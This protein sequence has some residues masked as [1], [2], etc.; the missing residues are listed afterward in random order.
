MFACL[1]IVGMYDEFGNETGFSLS[2]MMAMVSCTASCLFQT[3]LA[4]TYSWL[5]YFCCAI[6]VNHSCKPNCQQQTADG[7]TKLVA[8]RDIF[9]GEELSYSYVALE[10]GSV[11]RKDCIHSNW[12]F[13]CN[14]ARCEGADCTAF[15]ADHVCICGAVC[16]V[17]DRSSG[18]D[19]CTCNPANADPK[20]KEW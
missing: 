18:T 16:L 13:H 19:L 2:P 20:E 10:G 7:G 15:D 17:V 9:A 12:G 3:C 14:C 11:E 8:L 5:S 1:C 6:Q 4:C